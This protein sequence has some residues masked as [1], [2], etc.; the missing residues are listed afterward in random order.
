M[1]DLFPQAVRHTGEILA[2]DLAQSA[3]YLLDPAGAEPASTTVHQFPNG[4][5]PFGITEVEDDV[6]YTQSVQ[7]N[8]YTLNFTPGSQQIWRVDMRQYDHTGQAIVVKV[9]D[10]PEAM[11]LNGM[12][13]LE[14]EEGT[15]LMA[16]IRAGVIYRL[17]A[18][19]LEYAVILDDPLLKPVQ[20]ATPIAGVN[21][22][23]VVDGWLYFSNSN[24]GILARVPI[25]SDGTP[26]GPISV[27]SDQVPA[28]DDFAVDARDGSLWVTLNVRR[29][30]VH[31]S[32][33][34]AVDLVV[35]G[36][37][38]TDL[39]GPTAV[40]FGRGRDNGTLYVSTDGISLDPVTEQVVTSAGKVAAVD[41]GRRGVECGDW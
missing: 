35:G 19:T 29:S 23:H 32:S 11:L 39:L 24:Q 20:G 33:A 25:A 3:V 12:C 18:R 5:L 7:G 14:K 16:D 13:L 9:L 4:T 41:V 2:T 36:V 1:T 22:I 8:V 15:V 28:V 6:F 30:L 26:T 10:I 40:V 37:S 34:G 21:G 17:N 27:I 38:S 31:V